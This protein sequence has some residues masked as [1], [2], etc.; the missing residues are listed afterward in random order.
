MVGIQGKCKM[1]VIYPVIIGSP[2][3]AIAKLTEY[4][5]TELT[6]LTTNFEPN[7][8]LYAEAKLTFAVVYP[9]LVNLLEW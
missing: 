2:A 3:N 8:L 6:G 4:G 1:L 7:L 9:Q 5:A